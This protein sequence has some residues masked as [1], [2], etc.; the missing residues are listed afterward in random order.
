MYQKISNLQLNLQKELLQASLKMPNK[1]ILAIESSCDETAAAV[2]KN[3]NGSIRIE[4]NIIASQADIH[5]E[6]GGVIPEIAARNHIINI[7]PVIK[8]ALDEANILDKDIDAI[9]VTQGPGLM[10]ALHV[11]VET[12]KALAFAWEKPVIPVNHMEGHIYSSLANKKEINFPIL[13]LL[14]SGGHTQL[15]FMQ[16][17]GNYDIVG[18]TV[19]DAVG[20]A[21]DKVAKMLNLP[22]PGGPSIEKTAQKG[23]S[24]AIDFPRPMIDAHNFYF[25]FSGL[26]T[27][28]LYYIKDTPSYNKNDVAA[29]FQAAAIEVLIAK[30][31]KAIKKHTPNTVV[32][33]GGVAANSL[34]RE[35]LEQSLKNHNV[36]LRVPRKKTSADNA[37]MIGIA[38]HFKNP[39][40]KPFIA[41]PN[42]S[43]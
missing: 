13:A 40:T 25:S 27:A 17:H 1:T 22:Y 24:N 6:Y 19:D 23:N 42:L 32:V 15:V 16:K 37:A 8:Q 18:E 33:G 31:E 3:N 2:V 11:G 21:F 43:F 5:A 12:A 30:T 38:A 7:I 35:K 34:L 28:V 14:V 4:S 41:S 10:T 39:S 20:E 36:E 29:S 26:K 9:A